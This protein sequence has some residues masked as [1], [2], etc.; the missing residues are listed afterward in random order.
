MRQR[1]SHPIPSST[2][3]CSAMR[4]VHTYTQAQYWQGLVNTL[5]YSMYNTTVG[6]IA[7]IPTWELTPG[8]SAMSTCFLSSCANHWLQHNTR[9]QKNHSQQLAQR[10]IVADT[11]LPAVQAPTLVCHTVWCTRPTENIG[12]RHLCYTIVLKAEHTCTVQGSLTR[13]GDCCSSHVVTL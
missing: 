7:L 5:T 3:Q 10:D 11:R 1:P 4:G 9:A 12:R 2:A 8:I 6:Y 13:S